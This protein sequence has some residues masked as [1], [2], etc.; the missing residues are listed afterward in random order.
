MTTTPPNSATTKPSTIFERLGDQ[1]R[2]A[3]AYHQLG[4][5]AQ[6]RGDYDTAEQRYHQSLTITSGSATRPAWPPATTSS[7]SSPTHRGTTTPPNSATTSPSPSSNGS[8]TRPAWPP[9]TTSSASSPIRG[10]YDTA[11]QRYHQSLTISERL[12]DQASM[13][14]HLQRPRPAARDARQHTKQAV[15]YQ[16]R[17]LAIRLNIGAP[18]A[19]NAQALARLRRTLGDDHFH[20]A[21]TAAGLD[22]KSAANLNA[23]ARPIRAGTQGL[24]LSG[25]RG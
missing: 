6:I 2:M 5:L 25:S 4:I 1:A 18:P 21:A 19:G 16:V 9:A 14:N 11:E 3:T 8:A 22:E 17:A 12:G 13:A 23:H 10:D 24:R 15:T 7:A 20:T